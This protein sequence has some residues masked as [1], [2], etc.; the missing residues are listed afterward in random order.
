MRAAAQDTNRRR[1]PRGIV[2]VRFYY[3]VHADT[4]SLLALIGDV[5]DALDS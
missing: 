2:V 4:F 5:V 1:I 3:E